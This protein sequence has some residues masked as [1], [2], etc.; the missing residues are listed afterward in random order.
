[1]KPT[2]AIAGPIV[3]Q[4]Y[5]API[6]IFDRHLYQKGGLILHMLRTMFGDE[7]FWASVRH[8]L[9]KNARGVVE[10]RD[11]MRALEEIS[12]RGLEQFFEQWLYRPGHPEIEVKLAHEHDVLT[13]SVKQTQKI[14]KENPCFVFP[15]V[16]DVVFDKGKS[17][18]HT[19]RV[20]K[21]T[22]SFS[23]PCPERPHFVVVDPE[24]AVLADVSFDAPLD[25]LQKQL[26]ERC[27]PR[28]VASSPP[29]RSAS[30]PTR[31]R[32]RPWRRLSRVKPSFGGSAPRR[33]MRWGTRAWPTRSPS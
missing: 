11:L 15:F 19:H 26:A 7:V 14:D 22:E 25:M 24:F 27:L 28:A 17:V 4:D 3:C 20:E 16:F 13:M 33:R 10:T 32:S 31:P 18:R 12:G 9:T 2:G 6:D 23:I 1:M 8:Y 5:D 30:G 29:R 21:G